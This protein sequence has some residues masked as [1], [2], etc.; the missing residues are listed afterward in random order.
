MHKGD[1]IFSTFKDCSRIDC[2][3]STNNSGSLSSSDDRY[4]KISADQKAL[5]DALL[6]L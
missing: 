1:L 3:S 5:A 4:H 6:N 2:S